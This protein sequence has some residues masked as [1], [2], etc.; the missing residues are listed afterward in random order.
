MLETR[1]FVHAGCVGYQSD[2]LA[3]QVSKL[4]LF[5]Y[6]QPVEDFGLLLAYGGVG[7]KPL[8]TGQSRQ[9][10]TVVS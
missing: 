4:V 7:S 5:Q 6:I 10:G 2:P 1:V 3:F 9:K 8:R